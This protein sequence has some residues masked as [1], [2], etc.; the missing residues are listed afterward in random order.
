MFVYVYT[1]ILVVGKTYW[2]NCII[3]I[4]GT[5]RS[6]RR[7]WTASKCSSSVE[8]QTFYTGNCWTRS[9]QLRYIMYS[10]RPVPLCMYVKHKS[11]HEHM[12]MPIHTCLHLHSN[13]YIHT[14]INPYIH[15]LKVIHTYA[16]TYVGAYIVNT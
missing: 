8:K 10:N 9:K 3:A 12:I 1:V 13:I 4:P 6:S 14:Y 15:T 2:C 16:H 7:Q 5:R 11:H